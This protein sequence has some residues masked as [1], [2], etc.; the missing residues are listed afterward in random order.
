MMQVSKSEISLFKLRSIKFVK[1]HDLTEKTFW[2]FMLTNFSKS[3][4]GSAMTPEVN[5]A[6]Q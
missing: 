4:N 1:W 5:D 6:G 3:A 2:L